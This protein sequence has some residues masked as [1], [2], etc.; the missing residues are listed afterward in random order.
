MDIST[1]DISP[2]SMLRLIAQ[3]VDEDFKMKRILLPAH[4][5]SGPHTAKA[6]CQESMLGQWKITKQ[7]VHAGLQDNSH[8]MGTAM[9]E[10]GVTSFGCKPHTLQLAVNT[11]VLS[12]RSISD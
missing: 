5:C 4:E 12:Q 10:C 11:A 6:I 2:V 3:W 8:K 9:E 1:S 7:R